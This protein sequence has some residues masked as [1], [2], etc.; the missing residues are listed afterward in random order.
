M[1][2]REYIGMCTEYCGFFEKSPRRSLSIA[3]SSLAPADQIS[4]LPFTPFH[5]NLLR[6][7]RL[8]IKKRR[9]AFGRPVIQ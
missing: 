6:P 1:V 4:V 8:G 2:C 7:R 5:E 3:V 9:A